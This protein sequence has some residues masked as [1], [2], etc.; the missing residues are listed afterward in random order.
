[1]GRGGCAVLALA[2]LACLGIAA[3]FWLAYHR[4]IGGGPA[5]RAVPAQPFAQVWTD[6]PVLLLG[7]GDSI[8]AGLGAEP[9][10]S[11]FDRLAGH[12]PD[13]FEEMRGR[14]LR[15]V[16]PRLETLNLSVSGT[17]SLQ[18]AAGQIP[19][20]PR[21]GRETLGWVVMT[22]G[23]ND[24][25]HHYGRGPIEEGALYGATYERAMPWIASF[26]RRLDGM[27]RDI[28]ARFP[29]GCRV[30]LADI[31]DPTDG[32]GDLEHAQA[33][34]PRWPDGLRILEA[35]NQVIR[36]C[37]GGCPSVTEVG[38][39]DAF[40]GHG[41]HCSEFWGRHYRREDPTYWYFD[42]LE[43]PNPRG[44]DAVRRVFL[45]EM[46]RVSETLE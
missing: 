45:L 39:R 18:H 17:T 33:M 2:M 29:G 21:Q 19:R 1:M 25:I 6:R 22:T 7:L 3:R 10:Y 38:L 32:V 24:L 11:Y 26:E 20:I 46:I 27:I 14:C 16:Y 36:R 15:R 40:L 37:A 23:G 44:Y 13:E 12:P 31:Y 41:L 43:D 35:Y 4:P 42:N 8:T 9:G 28:V 34:L 30:F 5:G